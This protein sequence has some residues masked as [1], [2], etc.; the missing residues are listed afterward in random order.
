MGFA[1]PTVEYEELDSRNRNMEDIKKA[2]EDSNATMVGVHGLA[3]MGKTT[4]VIEAINRVQNREPK[5]FDI[6]IMANVTKSPDIRKIQ[7]QIADM[8]GMTL[9]EESE[10][11][12]AIRIREKLKKGKNTLIIL[13]DMYAKVDLY[14]LGIPSQISDVD[15]KKNLILKEGIKSSNPSGA[16][17][18]K[19]AETKNIAGAGQNLARQKTIVDVN[20]PRIEKKIEDTS[21]S[22]SKIVMKAA[23]EHHKGCKVLLISEAKR[24]LSQMDV[25]ANLIIS[26][27]IINPDD[28]KKLFK[29]KVGVTD[30]KNSELERLATDI[31]KKCHGLPMSIVTTAKA[32]KNQSRSVWEHTLSTLEKQKLTGTPQYSTKLSY[33]L[34]ENEEL[35]L[36]LLL[37]ACMGQDAFVSDLVR[38]C[39]GFGFLEG[40]HTVRE[41]RDKVQMLL[42]QLK[43]SGLLSDS[44][45]NDRFTMQNLVRNAALSIASEKK[46][47]FVLTKRK[48]DEWPDDD[49]LERYTAIFLHHCDVNTEEFPKSVRCPK[50]KVFHFLNNHQHLKIPKDF[51]QEMKELRVL[52]LIGIDLSEFLS[53][54]MECLTKLRK[55]CLEQCI[56]LHKDLCITIGKLMKN[57]RILSFSGSDIECLPIELENLSK[58]QILDLSNCSELQ[59]IP[60]HLISSL[61]SLEE[62]YMR[63]T[64]VEWSIDNRQKSKN[65][66]ASLSELGQLSQISNVDLHI[67]SV[68]HLPKNLF[69]DKLYSYKIVIGSSS[70]HLEPDF[71]M[72]EKYELIRYLAIQEKD[73]AFDIHSQK[74]IKMLFERVENLLLEELNGVQDIFYAL[75]LKGFPCL[76][77]LSI[78]SS[79]GIRSLIKPQ[80]RKHPENAFPKLEALHLYKLN[81]MEQLCSCELS[82]SS[83]R[84]LKV[85]KI[86]L[87]GLLKNVF[88]ISM[89][90]LLVALETIE[91]SECNSLKEI[92]CVET[93][94]T[95]NASNRLEFQELRTLTLK[96][97]PEFH[98][99]CRI[100]STAQ[101]KILFNEQVTIFP[102]LK[103]IKVRSMKSLRGICKDFEVPR[104][105]FEKLETL[106]MD[107]CDKLVHVFTANVVEI[108]KHISNL[109]VTN[110]KSMK[111]IFDPTWESKSASKDATTN[112]QDV[113]LESLPKLEHVFKFSRKKNQLEGILGL[114]NLRKIWVQSCERLENIFSVAVA[115]TL[116]NNLEDLVVSD[117]SQLREIVAMEE[118]AN[119]KISTV[120]VR[121]NFLKLA[122]I[123][124]FRLPK[125]KT[126]YPG[127]YEI[128][129]SALNNL[130]IEECDKLE[131]FREEIVKDSERKLILFPETG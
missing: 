16:A 99:F 83:F 42:M 44:Y 93:Q 55:L 66:N 130:S 115:K 81:N 53:S 69:F 110:C 51:F 63:N 49:K 116:E 36:T 68:A 25:K 114:N 56:N 101:Q 8:L 106:V 120:T 73:G 109:R 92:V 103:S 48:L 1:L 32:L 62:L 61:T 107:E 28:A 54:S 70:T 111:A 37:C 26:M 38:L 91:V 129:F 71:K 27:D 124:F 14:M 46:D 89:V 47:V 78:A 121:F 60:P 23:Q 97:L 58:L 90:K 33:E 104:D 2:L 72:P 82:P 77:T 6:V 80:E 105:S 5:L 75:N 40:I 24:V 108:F 7:G 50:L 67:P 41:A 84:K 79:S 45:S 57:L 12:R 118:D 102:N 35:K 9:Q 52:V 10:Y 112:L 122:T 94:D 34:L 22:S 74:G 31:S 17:Q 18:T 11:A 15:K 127:T 3:G 30:D 123:K 95:N 21:G 19:T 96:S 117:C 13:D 100:S 86:K 128:K 43:E 98:G 76:K 126:F 87:C 119:S 20:R 85:V 88:L 131:P 29:K 39:I 59:D 4:L 125:F 113:H 65:K 64:S